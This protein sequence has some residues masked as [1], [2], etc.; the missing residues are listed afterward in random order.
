MDRITRLF[1]MLLFAAV[2]AC[3]DGSTAPKSSQLSGQPSFDRTQ[4]PSC[5]ATATFTVTDEATLQAASKAVKPGDVIAVRGMIGLAA[6]VFLSTPDVTVTCATPNA[7]LFALSTAVD[8]LIV[9]TAGGSGV[10]VEGLVLDAS[11]TAPDVGGPYFAGDTSSLPG[12]IVAVPKVRF[13][14][15]TVTCGPGF[16]TFFSGTPGAMV[17][18]N[19]FKTAGS[20]T[21]I[22]M[23]GAGPTVLAVPIDGSRVEGNTVVTTAPPCTFFFLG[24][25][26]PIGGRGVVIRDNVVRGSWCASISASILTESTIIDNRFEGAAG[27]GIEFGNGR[28]GV[29]ARIRVRNTVVLHNAAS[30]AG[31]AGLEAAQACYNTFVDNELGGNA[32]DLGIVL[33]A[34]TG[35]NLVA[36]DDNALVLDLGAFDCAGDGVIT[37]NIIAGQP[38]S[39]GVDPAEL[40]SEHPGVKV[41]GIVV[42]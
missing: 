39:R 28:G 13:S 32:G 23:Q 25:I 6:D 36:G 21:G 8:A 41:H 31:K 11:G 37:P 30:G 2:A 42:Q 7:G 9:V 34:T 1:P 35:A 27:N 22:Q 16:C 26:R 4:S 24:G 5:P 10:V 29:T 17:F 14:N 15:N 3:G 20:S 38:A 40:L 33:A 18:D 12:S 19:T